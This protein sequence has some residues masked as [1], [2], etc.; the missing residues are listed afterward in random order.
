MRNYALPILRV[1]TEIAVF[2]GNTKLCTRL[3]LALRRVDMFPWAESS[4]RSAWH[5]ELAMDCHILIYRTP[6]I[7]QTQD[8]KSLVAVVLRL[9]TPAI[10]GTTVGLW[11]WHTWFWWLS[12]EVRW[13]AKCSWRCCGNGLGTALTG[14]CLTARSILRRILQY[15]LQRMQ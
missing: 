13:W 4:K 14:C 2:C 6:W 10:C 15:R 12:L 7:S 3:I 1:S 5:M 11:W 9:S 8:P